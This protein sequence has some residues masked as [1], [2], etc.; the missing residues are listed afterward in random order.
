MENS[1]Y[2]KKVEDFVQRQDVGES[3]RLLLQNLL[4]EQS[5]FPP[6]SG[7]K[8]GGLPLSVNMDAD[9]DTD[10]GRKLEALLIS[11]VSPL[12]LVGSPTHSPWKK[13]KTVVEL[14]ATALL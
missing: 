4:L 10:A 7:V 5:S 11:P 1:G 6:H 3:R 12:E 13:H 9:L 2:L 14:E 8:A